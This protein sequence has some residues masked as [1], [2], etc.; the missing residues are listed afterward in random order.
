MSIYNPETMVLQVMN[1]IKTQLMIKSLVVGLMI[2]SVLLSEVWAQELPAIRKYSAETLEQF[3]N[4]SLNPETE[5][6]AEWYRD[7]KKANTG[8]QAVDSQSPHGAVWGQD[9]SD[10]TQIQFNIVS[11]PRVS[12][13]HIARREIGIQM[14]L[15]RLQFYEKP[16]LLEAESP[17]EF[18]KRL[19][20]IEK[21]HNSKKLA[22]FAELFLIKISR[23]REAPSLE[24]KCRLIQAAASNLEKYKA[25]SELT[26]MTKEESN[27]VKLIPIVNLVKTNFSEELAKLTVCSYRAVSSEK[28]VK[29]SI[30]PK[31]NEKIVA[32]IESEKANTLDPIE[33][34]LEDLKEFESSIKSIDAK[35]SE[36]LDL[37]MNLSNLSSN[38]DLVANDEL[39]FLAPDGVWTKLEK[40]DLST[41]G[42]IKSDILDQHSSV[43]EARENL[44]NSMQTFLEM[45][46]ISTEEN[47]SLPDSLKTCSSL[48]GEYNKILPEPVKKGQE[49]EIPLPTLNSSSTLETNYKSC[50][51]GLKTLFQKYNQV[52]PNRAT[53]EKFAFYLES[54]SSEIIKQSGLQP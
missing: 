48:K 27:F 2:H 45:L 25:A 31:I 15:N 14:Y 9:S 8:D 47:S 24:N 32:S 40:V 35:T 42:N 17:I 37:E 28:K 18:R 11:L 19:L 53:V 10:D 52:D 7:L 5:P 22:A 43:M 51:I 34:S 38:I 13:H 36:L 49:I 39:G 29:E 23:Y 44:I 30:V 21:S 1:Q 46:S 41:I 12:G 16:T 20:S 50:L 4:N 33:D 26:E 3:W 6:N 54:L